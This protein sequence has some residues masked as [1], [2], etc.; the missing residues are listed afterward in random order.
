MEV[1]KCK[2]LK[3]NALKEQEEL[4]KSKSVKGNNC[5]TISFILDFLH[6]A[7]EQ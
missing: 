7:Q 6:A 5:R 2:D 4:G 1:W 3:F